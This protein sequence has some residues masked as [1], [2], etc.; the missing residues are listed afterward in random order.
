M[1]VY[2]IVLVKRDISSCLNKGLYFI[3]FEMHIEVSIRIMIKSLLI[4]KLVC[5]II[6]Y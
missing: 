4:M 3:F 5:D 1:N 2:L 6:Y